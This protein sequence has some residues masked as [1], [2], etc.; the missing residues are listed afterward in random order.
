MSQ[1]AIYLVSG[2]IGSTLG[3]LFPT[4]WGASEFS[5]WGIILGTIGGVVGIFLA[6]RWAA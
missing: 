5:M 4:L 6:Y 2:T 3:G 1:R